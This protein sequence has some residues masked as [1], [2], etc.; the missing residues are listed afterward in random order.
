MRPIYRTGAPLPSRYCI[1]YLFSINISTGYF[2]HAAHC[3]VA[4]SRLYLVQI[5]G[6]WVHMNTIN[7]RGTS[8]TS[9]LNAPW[10]LLGPAAK[11]LHKASTVTFNNPHS[12]RVIRVLT[13]QNKKKQ[14]E[15]TFLC[16]RLCKT[17]A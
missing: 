17:K 12:A 13:N 1:P 11:L 15:N 2:K 8:A 16:T 9:L 4:P 6:L 3:K 7:I 10:S 14:R 5:S